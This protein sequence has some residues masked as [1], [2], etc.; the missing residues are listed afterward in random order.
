MSGSSEAAVARVVRLPADVDLHARPAGVLVRAAATLETPVTLRA[1]GREA[2]AR[3]ILQV[4]ALGATRGS[5]IEVEASGEGAEAAV[6]AV[7]EL[8]ATLA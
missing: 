8:L 4:L 1:N 3:S 6:D 5:T 7:A 2:S